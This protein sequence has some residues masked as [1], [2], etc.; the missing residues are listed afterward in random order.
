[1][2]QIAGRILFP[3]LDRDQQRMQIRNLVVSSLAI[4]FGCGV[5]VVVILLLDKR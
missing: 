4:V 3:K 5:V 1:M 2:F